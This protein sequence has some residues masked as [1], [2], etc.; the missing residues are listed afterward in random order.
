MTELSYTHNNESGVLQDWIPIFTRMQVHLGWI[1]IIAA[2]IYLY[3]IFA[4]RNKRLPA[5]SL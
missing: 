4:P 5:A 3:M 1:M 2:L